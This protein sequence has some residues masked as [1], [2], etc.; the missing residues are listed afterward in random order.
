MC[1]II[2]RKPVILHDLHK[3]EAFINPGSVLKSPKVRNSTTSKFPEKFV[4]AISSGRSGTKHLS[5]ILGLLPGVACEHEPAPNFVDE[6]QAAQENSAIAVDFI[7]NKKIPALEA[8]NCRIYAEISSLWCKGLLQAWLPDH[9]LPVPDVIILDRDVRLIAL[10][11]CR[12]NLVPERTVNGRG[13]YIGPGTR[14]ALLRVARPYAEW[15][16][17]QLC[18]WYALE[19]EARKIVLGQ[20]AKA[21]GAKVTRI[22]LTELGTFRG[23]YRMV[24]ELDLPRPGMPEVYQLMW[25]LRQKTNTQGSDLWSNPFSDTQLAAWELEVLSAVA[26]VSRSE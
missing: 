11:L 8:K 13:W 1:P 25:F 24:R 17:Y 7:R 12:L 14:G 22:S 10:S 20:M 26:D 16:D 5:R 6:M 19:V 2:S 15:S 4:V 9:S 21:R 18:Y 23:I 3:I